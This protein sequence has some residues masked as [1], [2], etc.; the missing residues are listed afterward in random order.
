[1][2]VESLMI[3]FAAED[4]F[5]DMIQEIPGRGVGH[6]FLDGSSI[7]YRSGAVK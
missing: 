2:F 7:L 1:M 5:D 3:F 6:C 4:I